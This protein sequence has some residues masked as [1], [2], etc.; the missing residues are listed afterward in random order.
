MVTVEA[1]PITMRDVVSERQFSVR[2]SQE[3]FD[4]IERMAK[5]RDR[6]I[7]WAMRRVLEKA[8][9]EGDAWLFD[10]MRQDPPG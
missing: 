4:V 3:T 5:E 1:Q 7:N 6:K 10:A 2:I 8:V 9:A